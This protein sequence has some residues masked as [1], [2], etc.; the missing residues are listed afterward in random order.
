AWLPNI[1]VCGKTGTAQVASAEYVKA[2]G[3]GHELKDNA[4]FVGF[5][6]RQSPEI[7][8]VALFEHGAEGPLAAPI[9]RDVLTA[10][11]DKKIRIE[12]LRQAAAA[13]A[14]GATGGGPPRPP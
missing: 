5:A 13:V 7:L 4:W 3:G 14:A 11:F 1:E 12:T 9:V 10:Y 8:V 2:A 6:P